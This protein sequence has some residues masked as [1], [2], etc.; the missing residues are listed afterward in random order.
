MAFDFPTS[1]TVGQSANGY[2][3]NGTA[4]VDAGPITGPQGPA[5]PQGPTGPAGATGPAG[6]QGPKGDP[7]IQGIQGEQ[8]PPGTDGSPDTGAQILAKLAPVDGA[9]SGLDADLLDGQHASAFAAAVHTHTT[10][11]ITGLDT[12]LA[13]K[14]PTVH[15]HAQGDVT[16]LVSDLA[17]KAPLA[18]PG[19]TGTPTAPTP[20]A[21]TNTTQIA[22]AAFVTAAVGLVPATAKVTI[23]DNDRIVGH[24]SAA[25]YAR[26]QWTW[27]L[28][29]STLKTYFDTLYATVAQVAP[30]FNSL[31]LAPAQG[32]Y[33][34][35]P[36]CNS[37]LETGWYSF[38]TTSPNAPLATYGSI[39]VTALHSAFVN[40]TAFIQSPNQIFTRAYTG[41]WGPWMRVMTGANVVVSTAAPSGG[42]DGDVWFQVV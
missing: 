25:S 23:A 34:S 1:P 9:S 18:S 11:Q 13:G 21:G 38:G 36:D 22:T 19:L 35:N 2:V 31:R 3:W 27:T 42:F 5:G 20:A 24:D 30:L 40:Q 16:N 26:V 17:A 8:G 14:A 12:A 28:F 33:V 41:T 4:W 6:I 39:M 29:K 7:G 10:A 37:F 32:S 15:T